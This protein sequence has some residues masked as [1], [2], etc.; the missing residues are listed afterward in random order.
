MAS[1]N[2]VE[3]IGNVGHCSVKQFSNGEKV[4]N[5]SLATSERYTNKAGEK[6]EETDWHNLVVG[7]KLAEIAERYITKGS[8]IFAAGRLKTRKYTDQ[9]GADKYVTE[10]RVVEIQLLDKPQGAAPAKT[11]AAPAAAPKGPEIP[12]VEADDDLLF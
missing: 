8:Q 10:V 6:V 7:G 12:E 9:S 3:L 4:A 11:A 2:R 5:I 1:F